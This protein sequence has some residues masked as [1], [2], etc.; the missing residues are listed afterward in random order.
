MSWT[1]FYGTRKLAKF[2]NNFIVNSFSK[3][4]KISLENYYKCQITHN[5]TLKNKFIN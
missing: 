3:Y 5:L 2:L 1:W 4:D